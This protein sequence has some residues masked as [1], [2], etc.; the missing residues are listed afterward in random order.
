MP[1]YDIQDNGADPF[2]VHVRSADKKI[3]VYK[4]SHYDEK[5]KKF[6]Y[7]TTP[8]FVISKYIKCFIGKNEDLQKKYF[9]LDGSSILVHISDKSNENQ[10]IYIGSS[11]FSFTTKDKI[12]KYYS[13]CLTNSFPY[14]FAISDENVYLMVEKVYFSKDLLNKKVDPYAYYY[15]FDKQNKIDKK[16]VKKLKTK[17]IIKRMW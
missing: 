16:N 10:Y 12:N 7:E 2:K 1:Y 13:P 9:K 6:I 4:K 3:V 15:G 14:P 17:E 5:N 8:C 11:L